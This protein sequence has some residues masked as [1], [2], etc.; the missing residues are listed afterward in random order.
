MAQYMYQSQRKHTWKWGNVTQERIRNKRKIISE[1]TTKLE[2]MQKWIN[3]TD[4]T[5]KEI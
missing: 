3:T 2:Q 5:S 4:A 1:K